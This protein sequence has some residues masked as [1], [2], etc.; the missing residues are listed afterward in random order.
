MTDLKLVIK[1][2][3]DEFAKDPEKFLLKYGLLKEGEKLEP[4]AEAGAEPDRLKG[5]VHAHTFLGE[6]EA[7]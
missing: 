2:K 1:G 3:G 4:E 5:G 6:A 7:F